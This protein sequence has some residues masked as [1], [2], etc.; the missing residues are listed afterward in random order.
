MAFLRDP[1]PQLSEDVV[2]RCYEMRDEMSRFTASSLAWTL[3][4]LYKDVVGVVYY[5]IRMCAA[6][7]SVTGCL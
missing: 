2:Q 4:M 7:Y 6:E 1:I 3:G 5:A